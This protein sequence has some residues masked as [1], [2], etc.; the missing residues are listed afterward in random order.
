[1]NN[2]SRYFKLDQLSILIINILGATAYLL[3]WQL[4]LMIFDL[5]CHTRNIYCK[6]YIQI[7]NVKPS[8]VHKIKVCFQQYQN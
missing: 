6:R 1:M 8:S 5:K 4:I 7:N 2:L 3:I